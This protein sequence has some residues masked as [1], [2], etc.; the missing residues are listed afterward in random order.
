VACRGGNLAI[1]AGIVYTFSVKKFPLEPLVKL[2]AHTVDERG[3]ALQERIGQLHQ[4]Q[5]SRAVA[6]QSERQH[7]AVRREVETSEQARLSGGA[8]TAKDFLLLAQYQV[9][10]AA[11]AANLQR[12]SSAIQQRLE[13]AE[14]EQVEAEQA[15]A[16][17]RAELRVVDDHKARFVAIERAAAEAS[18]EEDALE[19]WG[20]RRV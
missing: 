1:G 17:A 19:V 16:E 11:V 8:A 18:A 6:E 15:L 20:S 5:K 3:E 9:G 14:R 2:R 10:A 12:Q 13:R 7:D 4:A